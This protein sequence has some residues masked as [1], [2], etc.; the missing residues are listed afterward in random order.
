MTLENVSLPRLDREAAQ[1]P[2]DPADQM[3]PYS[4]VWAWGDG[5]RPAALLTLDCDIRPNVSYQ[6]IAGLRIMRVDHLRLTSWI[7]PIRITVVR[8]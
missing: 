4:N 3:C 6:V 1:A 7:L 5:G 2:V 8:R